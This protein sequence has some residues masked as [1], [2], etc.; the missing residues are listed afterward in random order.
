[1][2]VV[3]LSSFLTRFPGQR[4]YQHNPDRWL[5]PLTTLTCPGLAA[6]IFKYG[7]ANKVHIRLNKGSSHFDAVTGHI[8]PESSARGEVVG[9]EASAAGEEMRELSEQKHTSPLALGQRPKLGAK[10]RGPP[11]SRRAGRGAARP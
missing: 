7:A 1:M 4:S 11:H 9:H 6:S 10:S 5:A 2:A 8:L 3:K